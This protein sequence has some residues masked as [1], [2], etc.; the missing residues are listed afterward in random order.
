MMALSALLLALLLQHAAAQDT[1][2]PGDPL[3]TPSTSTAVALEDCGLVPGETYRIGLNKL[4]LPDGRVIINWSHCRLP[5]GIRLSM[6]YD[7]IPP[8]ESE[9]E[10]NKTPISQEEIQQKING[11]TQTAAVRQIDAF[12]KRYPDVLLLEAR[13]TAP[14]MTDGVSDPIGGVFVDDLVRRVAA[15]GIDQSRVTIRETVC[16]SARH[17]VKIEAV[18]LKVTSPVKQ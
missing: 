2:K 8:D 12:L 18:V 15:L 3:E 11:D 17:D 6:Q 9:D 14:C 1:A 13:V 5:I 10:P 4:Q 7:E 16:D